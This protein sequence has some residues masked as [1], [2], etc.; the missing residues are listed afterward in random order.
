LILDAI[1]RARYRQLTTNAVL[2]ESHALIMR[3]LGRDVAARFLEELLGSTTIFVRVRALDER[4]ARDIIDRYADKDFSFVDALSFVVMDR[5][6]IRY[7][8]TFDQHFAQYG[9]Q[10]LSADTPL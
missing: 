2:Y 6:G 4:R 5:L 3:H 10:V 9:L 8:F 7:A 1:M